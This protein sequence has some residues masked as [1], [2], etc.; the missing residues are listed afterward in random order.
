MASDDHEVITRLTRIE[1]KL[2]LWLTQHADHETRI[3][4]LERRMWIAMG[5]AAVG[6]G[7]LSQIVPQL[8]Q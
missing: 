8:F 5:A 1:T 3:R 6:G 7:A 2:E 4:A